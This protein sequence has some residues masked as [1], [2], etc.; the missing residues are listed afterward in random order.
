MRSSV[1][2]CILGA[3][4]FTFPA[5]AQVRTEYRAQWIDTFNTTLNNHT[6]IVNA[7][8]RAKQANVNAVIVQVRR[9]GDAWYIS[10]Y[11]PK[12]DGPVFSPAGFDPLADLL[13]EAHDAGLEVHAWVIV[14]AIWN[15]SPD[16]NGG[17]NPVAMPSNSTPPHPFTLH[18]G[19][20]PVTQK[21]VDVPNNWLTKTLL[22]DTI[23]PAGSDL[24]KYVRNIG[25]QG[26]R[27]SSDFWIDL[28]HP[29]AAE[30]TLNVLMA[31]VRNYAIDGLHLDRIRYPEFSASGQ[32]P[33]NGANIGYNPVSVA[34][35]KQHYGIDPAS[36]APATGDARWAQWRRDQVTNF[37]RRVY[38]TATAINPK[39]RI[40]A[41]LI[42]FGGGPK[43]S[44]S[45]PD[46]WKN[47]E[48]YWRVYQD[49]DAW[50]REGILDLAIPMDYK[51]E[52]SAAQQTQFNE[53]SE[54]MKN[55]QYSR[56]GL[57]GVGA[58]SNAIEGTLRQIRRA[59]QPSSA[60]NS[61][62]GVSLYSQAT[63]NIAINSP[64]TNPYAIPPGP[65]PVRPYSEFA[66]ALTTGKSA[67][68]VSPVRYYEDPTVY[69]AAIFKDPAAVPAMPWKPSATVGHLGDIASLNG[70]RVDT[71]SVTIR[72]LSTGDP[73]DA[74]TDGNGFFGAVDVTPGTYDVVV[75]DASQQIAYACRMTI[76]AG[77]VAPQPDIAA[78]APMVANTDPHLCTAT[79]KNFGTP[80]LLDACATTVVTAS[81]AAGSVFPLGSSTVT[82]TSMTTLGRTAT[83]KQSLTVRDGEPPQIAK[84]SADPVSLWPVNHK[85]VR[86]SVAY[87]TADNCSGPVTTSLSV[88]SNEGTA[89][90]W[91]VVDAHTV[92][93]RAER[94][95]SGG[96]RIYTITVAATDAA[97][98]TSTAAVNVI[99]PHDQGVN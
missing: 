79:V 47:A 13:K 26:H 53:W 14:G 91:E 36:D 56:M 34:R 48:A 49:W 33:S 59:L 94:L 40:S 78:P 52:H 57:V 90:D 42:A 25:Y 76:T 20:D 44:T 24:T 6:D 15:K 19:Y 67:P 71:G 16:A 17:P 74:A 66:S 64:G 46:P 69:P 22:S 68:T 50:V 32:T 35:F 43:P 28:G 11:E 5:R 60:A 38:V 82:W 84:L 88:S 23:P 10:P 85:M 98:N 72:N 18:G 58:S 83:A 31:L 77:T 29:D 12:P 2:V 93:L 70:S 95:G 63:S 54:W 37:V 87:D 61:A 99:V 39:I 55:H 9:R 62:G 41:S 96:D 30:Y 8:T 89:D 92:R 45:V 75:K 21:V 81:P 51:A 65:T 97:N 80:Q 3:L 1:A 4:L 86:V 73:R 27:F 7:V